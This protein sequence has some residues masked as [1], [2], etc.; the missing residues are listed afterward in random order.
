MMSNKWDMCGRVL[1]V[2]SLPFFVAGLYWISFA[3][4]TSGV[5]FLIRSVTKGDDDNV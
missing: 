4:S 1:I 2:A 5:I 3:L